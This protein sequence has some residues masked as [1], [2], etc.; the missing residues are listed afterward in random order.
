[1]RSFWLLFLLFIS[2][3]KI[4]AQENSTFKNSEISTHYFYGYNL[5]HSNE[6]GHLITGK[7]HGF[8]FSWNKKTFGKEE[9]S[10]RF[11]YPDQGISFIHQDMANSN[12]GEMYGIYGHMN[13][14]FFN[15]ILLFREG[16]GVVLKT[17]LYLVKKNLRNNVTVQDFF[18]FLLFLLIFPKKIIIK[19]F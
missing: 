18:F 5:P 3:S 7:P 15:D 9:W 6:I 13:F 8:V 11:N 4:I 16:G 1:M 12:L 14:Y 17:I 2:S 19:V 10:R